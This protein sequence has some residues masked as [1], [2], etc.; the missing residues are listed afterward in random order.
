MDD[1]YWNFV[2]ANPDYVSKENVRLKG[3][4]EIFH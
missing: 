4:G 3:S 2:E 1:T